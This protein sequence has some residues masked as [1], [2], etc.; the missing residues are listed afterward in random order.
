M[1]ERNWLLMRSVALVASARGDQRARSIARDTVLQRLIAD[2][3]SART[4]AG[5]TQDDVAARM[6]TT[7]SAI[8]RLESGKRTRPT[9]TTIENYAYA[10]GARLDV[11]VWWPRPG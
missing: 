8:C 10:V 5:M 1:D 2:L 9:L 6:F 11:C 7:K 4:A 3:V